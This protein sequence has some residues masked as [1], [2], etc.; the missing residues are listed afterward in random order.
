MPTSGKYN[1]PTSTAAPGLSFFPVSYTFN[2]SPTTSQQLDFVAP[3]AHSPL[4]FKLKKLPTFPLGILPFPKLIV[5][6][7]G[8]GV[9]P[10][11]PPASGGR[12]ASTKG[13]L[14]SS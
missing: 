10:S 3:S 7:V 2:V 5:P 4:P 9:P 1:V 14:N 8:G 11:D 13:K 12:L 6:A